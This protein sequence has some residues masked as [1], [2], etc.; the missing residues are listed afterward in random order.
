MLDYTRGSR[1]Q[2]N[3]RQ[4][5]LPLINESCGNVNVALFHTPHLRG[6]LKTFIPERFNETIGLSH[7]KVY[8]FDNDVIISG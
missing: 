7:L 4:M 8:L 2:H 5:L 6:L 3:S 1:G